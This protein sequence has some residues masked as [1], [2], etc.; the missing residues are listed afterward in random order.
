MQS[1]DLEGSD[2]LKEESDPN[3]IVMEG[4]EEGYDSGDSDESNIS[5][6]SNV[7]SENGDFKG[8][9]TSTSP[10]GVTDRKRV[11]SSLVRHSDHFP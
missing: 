4:D 6:D 8:N 10:Q 5:G 11:L 1:S 3:D 2:I 9:S 7:T